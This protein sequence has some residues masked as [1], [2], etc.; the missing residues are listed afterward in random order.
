MEPP[1]PKT[2]TTR[3]ASESQFYNRYAEQLSVTQLQPQGVFAP[4]CLE[5]VELLD[6][7]G[8]VRGQ[9]VLDIG[10][11]QG[12]TSVAFAL[13]GAEVWAIDVS[14]QMVELTRQLAAH[15]GVGDR[16][17]AEV[18]PVEAMTYPADFFDLIF[19]DGVLHH[20]DMNEAVPNL[21]RVL[22]PGGR[23]F[24]LEPQKGS[25]FIRIY[26]LFATDLR[27]ADERPLEPGDF[28]F[29]QRQFGRLEHREYHLVSLLLFG[30]RFVQLKL[31]GKAF[32]YWMDDVRQGKC[33]PRVLRILQKT[34][35]F[36]LGHL[37]VLRT[38]CWM[39]VITVE[40]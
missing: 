10:C 34:D 24:F 25:I 22:K 20:L 39:T 7:L 33:H 26:R 8:D 18:C 27:T 16:V 11:G 19:A 28:E 31:A 2:L 4:T 17:K 9:R 6:Q 5:N 29:L 38:R 13:R 21:V 12:D 23:G 14:Q 15:H 32:P 36:L 37:P 3:A 1:Q 40:K 30:A 35:Q